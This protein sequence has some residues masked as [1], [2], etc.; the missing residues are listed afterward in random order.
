MGFDLTLIP[1]SNFKIMGDTEWNGDA[2]RYFKHKKI[3]NWCLDC[4]YSHPYMIRRNLPNGVEPCD[5]YTTKHEYP[6]YQNEN[7]KKPS[8]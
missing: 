4:N 6:V 3:S 8:N 7:V 5:N 1:W 2:T